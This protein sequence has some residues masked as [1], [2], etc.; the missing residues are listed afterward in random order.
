MAGIIF[1][2]QGTQKDVR[3]G[4][5]VAADR[6]AAALYQTAAELTGLDLVTLSPQQLQNTRWAQLAIVTYSLALWRLWQKRHPAVKI[7]AFAG[8]SLG[9]Y[10]ALAAAG[11]LSLPDLITLLSRRAEYMQETVNATPGGM[12]AL[13]GIETVLVRQILAEERWADRV[14]IANENA[15][16]QTVIAG[17]S[18]DLKACAETMKT[19]GARR[20][21]PLEVQGAFHTPLMR[22]AAEKLR[23]TAQTF[24]F[25]TPEAALYL[26]RTAAPADPSINWPDMLAGHM[27]NPVRWTDEVCRMERDGIQPFCEF[28][29]GQ[30]LTGLIRRISP[31]ADKTNIS[32]LADLEQPLSTR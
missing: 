24:T 11:V 28:G 5:L 19:A 23:Q 8:F 7:Q 25:K 13:I 15:P 32:S 20:I 4:E 29:P 9:E 12:T 18:S 1:P 3:S 2:G 31:T 17:Y 22:P 6:D 30:V 21:V 10:T 26:N 16:G 14:W 27:C